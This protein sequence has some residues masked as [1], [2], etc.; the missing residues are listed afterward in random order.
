MPLRNS[1]LILN[2]QDEN[3]YNQF[4]KLLSSCKAFYFN[5][6]FINYSGLQL[7]LNELKKCEEKEVQGKVLTSTYLNFTELKALEKLKEFTNIQLKIFDCEEQNKGFHPKAYIFEYENEFKI[8]LGSSNITASA[9]KSNIEW[10]IKTVLKKEESFLNDIFFEFNKLFELSYFVDE[11]FLNEY[12]DFK[13]ENKEI[14]RFSYKQRIRINAMQKKA[15]HNLKFL[16]EQNQNKALVIASTGTGKTYLS[17]FDVK[18]FN[19]KKML[20]IVHREDI[21]ISARKSFEKIISN[22]EM[23][24]FTGNKKDLDCEYIFTTIQTLSKHYKRFSSTNF[25]YIIVDEAHHIASKSYNCIK[26]YF[27]PKFLLGLTATANRTDKV[28]IYDYFDDNL[29]YEITLNEALDENL[30]SSFHYFGIED[31]KSIDYQE[32]NLND[33][34]KLSKL[35]MVNK[36]VD[37]IISKMNF[38]DFS[39]D[40]RRALGFCVNKEHAKFM[41]EEF[42]KRGISSKYLTSDDSIETRQLYINKLQSS[43]NDLQVIFTVDIFNEGVDIPNVNT[44]LMLRPTNSPIVFI[45]QLGRGLRKIEDKK[46]LTVLDF[47][48]NHERSYMVT[49]ALMGSKKIDKDSMKLSINNNFSNFSNAYII[50]DEISKKRVLEQIENENFNTLKYLKEQYL[51]F[52]KAFNFN[53]IPRLTD[54]IEYTEYISILDFISYSKSYEEF[55]LKVEKE[56]NYRK[57]CEDENFL[58]AIRFLQ[59]LLPIK[60]PYEMAILKALIIEENLNIEKVSNYLN[61]YLQEVDIATCEHSFRY[62]DQEFFDSSQKERF[63]KLVTLDKMHLSLSEEF[64]ILLENDLKKQLLLETINYSLIEYEKNF[65]NTNYGKPF[66]KLYEKYNMQNIALL[67]NFDKIHSSFRGSG[68]LKYKEDFFLFI[69][70][71]KDKFTKGSKYHNTF[72]SKDIL[73]YSS[74]PSMSQDKGDG[75]KLIDNKKYDVRLHIFVRKFSHVDKKVQGFIYLGLANTFKYK[76]NKPIDLELKLEKELT[77]NL[78]EEFTKIID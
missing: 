25:D 24:F 38:Y 52:K 63:L 18:Q 72:L 57:I 15:L 75:K 28:S 32:V 36:R 74:K 51:E 30:V 5:V 76:N 21:L 65:S 43:S 1:K 48:G 41:C 37:Y 42:K 29:A 7:I 55:I 73:T 49:K 46:F 71:E 16:R 62:L 6:A 60:R 31:L 47:I 67:C 12:R 45:Q 35:L 3:F 78:Y 10:N 26:E 20:F 2:T 53:E 44:L 70:I 22:K 40:K 9:F 11:D 14:K 8:L 23:G 66:L 59:G 61:K 50:M 54:F 56:E 64:K 19:A 58:K 33:I 13:E 27:K 17:A 34:Q 39:G 68:F 4:V 69:T 77:S